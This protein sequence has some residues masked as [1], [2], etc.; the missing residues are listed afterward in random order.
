M[1]INKSILAEVVELVD[2]HAWGAC[3]GNSVWV[4]V[5]PSAHFIRRIMKNIIFL[6]LINIL[7]PSVN[8]DNTCELLKI[9]HVDG[10]LVGTTSLDVDKF[11]S[12][13]KQF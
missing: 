10:F 7:F 6:I 8:E 11:Y 3:G 5:P 13:Y 1:G 2:T 12:I 9:N 4:R